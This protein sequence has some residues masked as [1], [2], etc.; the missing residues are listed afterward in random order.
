MA[1]PS[2]VFA[3]RKLEKATYDFIAMRYICAN[4]NPDHDT[5][6]S[7]RQRFMKKLEALFV[8]ILFVAQVMGLVKLG[9]IS[10][11]GTKIKANASKHKA[12]SWEYAN[13]LEAQ[14]KAEVEELMRFAEEADQSALPEELKLVPHDLAV[15]FIQKRIPRRRY[16]SHQSKGVLPLLFLD[17]PRQHLRSKTLLL[18][19]APWQ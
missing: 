13:Y 12:L 18:A 8:E 16:T 17:H 9:N 14:L 2:G 15:V 19:G 10:L 11:D 3:S 5:I 7:F 4:T 1:M 6:A